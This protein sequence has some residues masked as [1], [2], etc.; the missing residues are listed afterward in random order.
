MNEEQ[1]DDYKRRSREWNIRVSYE[2]LHSKAYT[3]L[4]YGPAIKLLNWMHEK[5]KVE[6]IQTRKGKNRYQVKDDGKFCFLYT[7]ANLRGLSDTQF[8]R[9]LRELHSHGFID[10]GRA[11]SAMKGDFTIYLLS[12]RWKYFDEP[13]FEEKEFPKSMYRIDSGFQVGHDFLWKRPKK[14]GKSLTIEINR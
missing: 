3:T 1:W 12:E 6:K 4:N 8:G 11:G 5:I 7:E 2:L 14:K 13:G 9:A 10:V